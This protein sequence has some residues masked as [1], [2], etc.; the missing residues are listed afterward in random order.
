MRV[1]A[2]GRDRLGR[3]RTPDGWQLGRRLLGA[4]VSALVLVAGAF[5]EIRAEDTR[6][7]R[8]R[9]VVFTA[10]GKTTSCPGYRNSLSTNLVM[11]AAGVCPV[12][13][14]S[15]LGFWS[16]LGSRSVPVVLKVTREDSVPSVIGLAWSG[17]A[18]EFEVYR[19]SS[20]VDLVG[21][22]NLLSTTTSCELFDDTPSIAPLLFYRVVPLRVEDPV[23]EVP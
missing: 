7:L 20:P 11:G 12:G 21:P 23:P 5:I 17:Q 16:I 13:T 1:S 22:W 9:R 6:K 2:Q 14:V 3:R 10:L 4:F 15:T 8:A 19:S 18:D